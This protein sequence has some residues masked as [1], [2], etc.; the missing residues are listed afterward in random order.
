MSEFSV[1]ALSPFSLPSVVRSHG[2][3]QLAPFTEDEDHA[4]FR[5]PTHLES[6]RVVDVTP[7]LRIGASAGLT[8]A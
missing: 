8:F 4:G 3:V 7:R 5:Y 1:T 2:W 6:G